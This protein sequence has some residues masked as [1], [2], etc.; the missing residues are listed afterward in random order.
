M[1]QLPDKK[2]LDELSE[3]KIRMVY[4]LTEKMPDDNTRGHFKDQLRH[5]LKGIRPLRRLTAARLFCFPFEP[6]LCNE[7][8][9]NRPLGAIPRRVVRHLWP[10]VLEQIGD[11]QMAKRIDGSALYLMPDPCPQIEYAEFFHACTRAVAA[12]HARLHT[13]RDAPRTLAAMYP[14]LPEIIEEIH[15]IYQMRE[16]ILMAKR[17]IL[18][19]EQ[20]IGIGDQY[21]QSVVAIGHKASSGKG[22]LRWYKLFF[23]VLLMDPE[24]SAHSGRLIEGLSEGAAM[25]GTSSV[26]AEL[27]EALVA[28]E[29]DALNT[30]F[31]LPLDTPTDLNAAADQVCS[32]TESLSV[33]RM[34]APHLNNRIGQGIEQVERRIHDFL[35]SRF[36]QAAEQSIASFSSPRDDTLPTAAQVNALSQTIM[37]VAKIQHAMQPFDDSRCKLD[38]LAQDTIAAVGSRIDRVA[39]ARAAGT[40][41][42]KQD[43]LSVAVQVARSLEPIG[44]EETVLRILENCAVRLGF[45]ESADPTEFF[46]KI[47][48]AMNTTHE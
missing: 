18:A 42:E 43:A 2:Q 35:G 17:Q 22:D 15:A 46:L 26:A 14:D 7:T 44:S 30:N 19:S 28:K 39:A 38:P 33:L 31:A 32:A 16:A 11:R 23:M 8:G 9:R 1:L 21:V 40:F 12:V 27:C 10:L 37:A 4:A 20:L 47:I 24:L 5:R 25:R 3:E 6:L 34:A 45:G 13:D 36:T 29:G 48:H 41:R